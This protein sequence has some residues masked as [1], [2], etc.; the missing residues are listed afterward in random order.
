MMRCREG[1]GVLNE[2]YMLLTMR[3]SLG[4]ALKAQGALAPRLGP[5][6]QGLLL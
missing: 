6:L 3:A 5:S 4:Q 2:T 1:K